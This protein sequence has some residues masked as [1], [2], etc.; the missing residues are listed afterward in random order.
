MHLRAC[1]TLF[2]RKTLRHN[3]ARIYDAYFV[4]TFFLMCDNCVYLHFEGSL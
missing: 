3:W 1:V 4:N 2:L